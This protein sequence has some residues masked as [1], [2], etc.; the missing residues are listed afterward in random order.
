MD[1]YITLMTGDGEEL[2][3][4]ELATIFFN[5]KDYAIL[6]PVRPIEGMEDEEAFVFRY[7]K[8]KDGKKV[9]DIVTDEQIIEA[10]FDEYNHLVEMQEEQDA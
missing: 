2:Q 7:H 6:K 10:V 4:E 8:R 5:T 1:E 3:F 9:Y